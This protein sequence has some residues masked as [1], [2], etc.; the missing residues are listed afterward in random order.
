MRWSSTTGITAST[1]VRFQQTVTRFDLMS[2]PCNRNL[3][4]D[5]PGFSSG[6]PRT[7]LVKLQ[8]GEG[9]SEMVELSE[10]NVCQ[11]VGVMNTPIA[12]S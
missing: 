7:L 6:L 1:Q 2:C 11:Y 10:P 8:C 9:D 4:F 5:N 3:P 12:C